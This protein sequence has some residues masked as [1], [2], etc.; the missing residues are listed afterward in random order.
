MPLLSVVRSTACGDNANHPRLGRRSAGLA[1]AT[2]ASAAPLAAEHE[3]SEAARRAAEAGEGEGS[4]WE[5][6]HAAFQAAYRAAQE[7]RRR[8]EAAVPFMTENATG[9]LGARDGG[10][11]FGVEMEFDTHKTGRKTLAM[12]TSAA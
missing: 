10:R 9:G 5:E 3:A 12:S 2:E 1:R 7:R 11:S 4:R 8:G 6:D